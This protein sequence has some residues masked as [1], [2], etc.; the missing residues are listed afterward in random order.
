MHFGF[1]GRRRGRLT[2][3]LASRTTERKSLLRDLAGAPIVVTLSKAHQLEI[4]FI[5]PLVP[6]TNY[7]YEHKYNSDVCHKHCHSVMIRILAS[8]ACV[9][10]SSLFFEDGVCV[11]F[12]NRFFFSNY[13]HYHIY[14]FVGIKS[15]KEKHLR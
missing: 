3:W 10:G 11:F 5:S 14:T 2:Q 6:H 8:H 4:E 9:P 15:N 13:F 1:D 12:F 7:R